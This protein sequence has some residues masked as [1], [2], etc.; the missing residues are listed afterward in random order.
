MIKFD[1]EGIPFKIEERLANAKL[2]DEEIP[3]EE[4]NSMINQMYRCKLY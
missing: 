2:V 1:L 4:L 3:I